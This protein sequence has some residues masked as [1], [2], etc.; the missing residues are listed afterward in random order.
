MVLVFSFFPDHHTMTAEEKLKHAISSS[1][2][3]AIGLRGGPEQRKPGE[4]NNRL[5]EWLG[6]VAAALL[7]FGI[8]RIVANRH[9]LKRYFLRKQGYDL[10]K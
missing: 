1:L 5:W 4:G 9:K 6:F 8:S 3:G 10:D 2:Q 7:I